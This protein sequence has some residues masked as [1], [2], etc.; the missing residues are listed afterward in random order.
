MVE[1]PSE[2]PAGRS[3][4]STLIWERAENVAKDAAEVVFLL[5]LTFLNIALDT[6]TCLIFRDS[7]C[8]TTDVTGVSI[9]NYGFVFVFVGCYCLCESACLLLPLPNSVAKQL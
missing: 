1:I 5:S 8:V 3:V 2:I 9:R 4:S 6:K 7:L